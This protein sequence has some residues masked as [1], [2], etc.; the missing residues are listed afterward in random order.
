MGRA[1]DLL[2]CCSRLACA[3]SAQRLLSAPLGL[4]CAALGLLCVALVLGEAHCAALERSDSEVYEVVLCCV[5]CG[6]GSDDN[7]VIVAR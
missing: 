6:L 4:L 3:V 7:C 1:V 2:C 5:D